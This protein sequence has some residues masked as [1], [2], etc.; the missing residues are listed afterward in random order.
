MNKISIGLSLVLILLTVSCK[1]K[2][3]TEQTSSQKVDTVKVFVLNKEPISK[4]ISLPA[5]LI[6]W[7]RSE[8]NVKVTGYVREINVD[9]G[10]KVKKNQVLAVLDA[11]EFISN[12]A[13]SSAELLMADAKY[14]SSLD[15]FNRVRQAAA[16]KGVISDSELENAKNQMLSDSS[17]LNAAKSGANAY[18]QLRNYLT[19]R[20]PFDGVITQRQVDAGALVS[21]GSK[22]LLVIENINRLKLR[23]AVPENYTGS[24]KASEVNFTVNAIPNESFKAIFLRRSNK[25]EATTRTEIWEYE[26]YN[27][28]GSLKSGMFADVILKLQRSDSAFAIPYTALVTNL[29]RNFVIRIRDNKTEWVDVKNGMSLSD[30]I[31]IFGSLEEGDLLVLKANDEIKPQVSFAVKKVNLNP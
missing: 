19:I 2:K 1:H 7:E 15:N 13:K 22:P 23:I 26:Y 24:L 17:A 9:I 14:R 4:I 21:I 27:R 6:P 25:I 18:A 11:P 31:E 28:S 10:D 12:Y 29:E 3:S 30:R 16:E 5:E 8:L 20:A